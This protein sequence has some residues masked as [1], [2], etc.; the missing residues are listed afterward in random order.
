[1]NY[2]NFL[3]ILLTY[4]KFQRQTSELYDMGFDFFEG[5][6]DLCDTVYTMFQST[7]NT[8]FK[9]EGVEW[10]EWFIHEN[11]WGIKDWSEYKSFEDNG[12]LANPKN[13]YGAFDENG[14]PICYSFESLWEYVKQYLK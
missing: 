4:Q 11:E 5:K 14:N 9:K 10:I 12:A 3:E 1:M 7:I 2:K 6:Y 13:V 8:L